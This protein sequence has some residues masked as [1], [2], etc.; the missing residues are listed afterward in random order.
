[1]IYTIVGARP[2]FIKAAMVSK[3]LIEQGVPEQIIHTGQHYDYRMSEIFWREL[4]LPQVVTNL[5]VGSGTQGKQTAAMIEKIEE[6]LLNGK[7]D[8][9]AVLL[10][11][12]TNST[13]AGAIAAVKLH[14]PIIH[15]EAGLRSFN[16]KMPEE[17]NRIVTDRLSS[18]LFCSSETGKNNLADEGIRDQVFV[19][20]DVMKDAV[21]QFS[22]LDD[23]QGPAMDQPFDLLTIHRPSN[24]EDL[25]VLNRILQV[26][27][28]P[29]K[30]IVW[31][32]HPRV[33]HK[34]G[35]IV[36][37]CITQIPPVGYLEMLQLIKN[38][39]TVLTDSGGLQK[40]AY[41]LHKRTITLRNE[42]EWTETLA[43]GCN[44]LVGNDAEKIEAARDH[45]INPSWDPNL[46]GDG[47]AAKK[48]AEVIDLVMTVA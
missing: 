33:A 11:G 31:P 32:V 37:S 36:P 39:D 14:I 22:T 21:L 41:W 43:N 17:I 9:K 47:K 19:V 8:G 23:H 1:M 5:N 2:Q 46:Y 27:G 26:L 40:E 20:G 38:C 34:K 28:Q 48:I 45:Q 25:S 18:L 13:L 4:G 10:Y 35:L 12:D 3:A 15:V 42:T 30:P 44:V 24:T 29:N 7:G 16:N 6:T